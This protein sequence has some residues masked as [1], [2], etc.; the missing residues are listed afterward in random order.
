MK[1]S[2]NMGAIN[3]SHSNAYLYH[4]S[5]PPTPILP[6]N[7]T[8]FSP[9]SPIPQTCLYLRMLL[10]SFITHNTISAPLVAAVATAAVAVAA[11]AAAEVAVMMT[12]AAAAEVAVAV[13]AAAVAAA[14][15]MA[16][17]AAAAIAVTPT[18][19]MRFRL[20]YFDFLDC[21]V[22]YGLEIIFRN[23]NNSF[24]ASDISLHATFCI[25][26]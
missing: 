23:L 21:I 5:Y 11:T 9:T 19:L 4:P 15:A 25:W 26:I 14:V 16:A 20:R 24:L 3:T 6:N 22:H 17:V 18:D 10:S 7:P 2:L 1:V 13:A 8:T 12:A